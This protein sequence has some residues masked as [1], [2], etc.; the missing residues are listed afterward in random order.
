MD[1]TDYLASP[2]V[3]Q[4]Q[5][6]IN[7]EQTTLVLGVLNYLERLERQVA[8]MRE[9]VKMGFRQDNSMIGDMDGGFSGRVENARLQARNWNRANVTELDEPFRMLPLFSGEY[10]ADIPTTGDVLRAASHELIDHMLDIYDIP[11]IPTMFLMEKKMLYLKF[12]G[13]NRVVMHRILD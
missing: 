11:F 10:P 3:E 5:F 4:L 12:V 6:N 1:T 7:Q 8:D 9:F 13:A 2:S